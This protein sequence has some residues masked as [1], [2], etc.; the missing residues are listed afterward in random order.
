MFFKHQED[1]LTITTIK[2]Y[3]GSTCLYFPPLAILILCTDLMYDTGSFSFLPI[4]GVIVLSE[5][6]KCVFISS[7]HNDS[8]KHQARCPA[9]ASLNCSNKWISERKLKDIGKGFIFLALAFFAFFVVAVLFGAEFLN[10]TEET[11][12]FSLM[13]TVLTA[14]PPCLIVGPDFAVSVILGDDE[15]SLNPL[16]PVL[17]HVVRATLF[18]AWLGAFVIPLDW[19]RPWQVWPVPCCVGALMGYV[20]SHATALVQVAVSR[21]FS[22][23]SAGK[24]I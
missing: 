24:L 4:L 10:K 19:D 6:L 20:A 7:C 5:C 23:R 2:F 9:K 17:Q 16:S 3:C 15:T 13:L 14:L 21:Y 11:F 12:M 18:G 8:E 22:K 1:Q